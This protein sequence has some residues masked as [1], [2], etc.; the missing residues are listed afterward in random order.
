M[1]HL[2][3][4]DRIGQ[5]AFG[6]VWLAFDQAVGEL[7]A[8]KIIGMS[9]V[10]DLTAFYAEARALSDLQHQN[11]VSVKDAGPIPPSTVYISMEYHPKGSVESKIEGNALCLRDSIRLAID[12]CWGLEYAHSRNYLHRDIKPGNILIGTND[13]GKLSDF[14]LATRV[15]PR[16]TSEAAGYT[17]HC[18]PE[19]FT[20]NVA[21]RSTDIYALGVT[22]YRMVN[23]INSKDFHPPTGLIVDDIILGKFPNRKKYLPYIPESLRRIIN[24]AMNPDQNNRFGDVSAFRHALEQQAVHFDWSR[25]EDNGTV[26]WSGASD[27][28]ISE[29]Q[30][31]PRRGSWS[32]E[33]RFARAGKALK[34]V[35]RDSI[36]QATR[37]QAMREASA[38]LCRLTSTGR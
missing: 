8:V 34:R 36:T 1:S 30:I 9:Q 27:I 35:T 32:L 7:R 31:K 25:T 23:R 19:M 5:G 38:L 15:A 37:E 22:L 29:I 11:I 12:V 6:E 17:P 18:A 14:G 13:D 10:H 3:Y 26:I 33:H 28:A 2:E 4:R 20:E 24:K 16:G 21:S